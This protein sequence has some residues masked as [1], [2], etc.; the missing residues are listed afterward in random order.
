MLL[1]AGAP[2]DIKEIGFN[3]LRSSRL[4]KSVGI[5]SAEF[6]QGYTPAKTGM[7]RWIDWDKDFIGK[8]GAVAER[9]GN[10][11]EL[12]VVTLEIDGDGAD[13]VGYEPVWQNGQMVGFVTSGGYGHTVNKSL[14]MAMVNVAAASD[15]TDL[16]VHVVGVERGAKVFPASPYDPSG[17]AMRG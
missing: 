5:W 8:A 17:K 15:D 10:E 13:P 14:A 12:C 9:D 3:A 6:T 4:E 11:P 16:T 1:E 7:D 2:E